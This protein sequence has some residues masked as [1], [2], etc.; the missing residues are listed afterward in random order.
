MAIYPEIKF[1][2]EVIW[3]KFEDGSKAWLR[4]SIKN[5]EMYLL[6]TY[7][8]PQHRGKGVA[9]KLVEKAIEIAKNRNL[10]IVPICSYT[11]YYFMKH[12]E[13]RDILSDGYRLLN[14]NEW[15]R[16]F[17]ERLREEKSKKS[18]D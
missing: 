16:L 8:P 5:N 10:K 2:K 12:T 9:S 6:E 4:Y 3:T 17:E 7:T 1:T 13:A 15:R 18:K 11:I 14:E